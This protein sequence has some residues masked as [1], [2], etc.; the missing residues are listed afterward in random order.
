MT[1][2]EIAIVCVYSFSE[3]QQVPLIALPLIALPLI[4]L[5]TSWAMGWP[6]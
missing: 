4:A 2:P 1:I 3:D 5:F 6:I